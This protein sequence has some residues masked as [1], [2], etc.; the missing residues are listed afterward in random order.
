M[1]F[2]QRFVNNY[3][4]F[5]IMQKNGIDICNM[6]NFFQ[7]CLGSRNLEILTFGWECTWQATLIAFTKYYFSNLFVWKA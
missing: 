3:S 1:I 6:A 7:T 2:F 4:A 5:I